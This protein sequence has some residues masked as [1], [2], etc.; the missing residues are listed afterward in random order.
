MT[1]RPQASDLS[2]IFMYHEIK[3]GPFRMCEQNQIEF[4]KFYR[5]MDKTGRII[6]KELFK[7]RNDLEFEYA[8][9]SFILDVKNEL[10]MK[11]FNEKELEKIEDTTILKVPNL[12]DE[13]TNFLGKFLGK[14][15]TRRYVPELD[16]CKNLKGLMMSLVYADNLKGY[17][18]RIHFNLNNI[19]FYP[20]CKVEMAQTKRQAVKSSFKGAGYR[21]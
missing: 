17:V 20:N 9:H 16:F 3:N 18:C 15:Y 7:L 8:I 1:Q 19:S 12:S 21:K 4:T 10:I 2:Y 13:I 11:H 5:V 6:K 14:N